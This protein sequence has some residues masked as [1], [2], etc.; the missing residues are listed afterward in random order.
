MN[1]GRAFDSTGEDKLCAEQRVRN[2]ST[3]LFNS[4]WYS[5]T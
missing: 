2:N 3:G 1:R 5:R 4:L